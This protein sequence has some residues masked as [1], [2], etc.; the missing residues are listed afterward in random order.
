[1]RD[2]GGEV[3]SE[4]HKVIDGQWDGHRRIGWQCGEYT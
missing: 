4:G 3:G 1:M 2:A